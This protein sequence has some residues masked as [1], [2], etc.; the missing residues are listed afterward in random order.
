MMGDIVPTPRLIAR[1][2]GERTVPLPVYQDEGCESRFDWLKHLAEE[3][4]VPLRDVIAMAD[5]LGAEEDFDGLV[6][7]VQDVACVLNG[8]WEA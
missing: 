3:N 8:H 6:T 7:S 2:D 1:I 4:G 5:V